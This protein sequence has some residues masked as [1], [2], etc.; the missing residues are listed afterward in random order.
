MVT[1]APW[2]ASLTDALALRAEK[3]PDRIAYIFLA[4][5]EEEQD[6][7]TYSALDT[8][9]RAIGAALGGSL[10]PGDRALLLYPPGL[11]FIAAFFGCLYAGV[12]AVPAYPPRSPRMIPRLLAMLADARPAV[13]LAPAT[14]LQRVRGWLER[15]PE[16]ALPW[17][18][19][20]ELEPARA[21]WKPAAPEGGAVAFLQYT[22]GSTSTPKGVMVT[23]GNLLHN[24]RLIQEACGHSEESVFVSWLPVYHDLGLIGQVLQ[25]VYVG[26][27][28]VLMAPVAFLQQ[29]M[30]WL[31]AVSRYRAT[32]S[33][34]PDFAY[35]LCAR[36]AGE[37]DLA[38]IDLTSWRVAFNG[39]EPVRPSTLERFAAAFAPC[40]FRA[41]AAYP[42]YGLAEATLMVSGGSPIEP[43]HVGSFRAAALERGLAEPAEPGEPGARVLAGCGRPLGDQTVLLV[44]P[45]TAEP[46][47]PGRIGEIWIAGPSVA[48]GYWERPGE[49]A[50]VFG[51]RLAGSDGRT[52]GPF[53]R[54]G[55]LGFLSGGELYV[56]G[57]IK[58]L[59]ILRGRNCYPQ[60]LELAAERSHPD[61]RPGGGAAFS[62]ESGGEEKL[63]LVHEVRRRPR[64]NAAEIAA[65]VRAALAEEH[66]VAVSEVVLIRPETLPRTSS[67]KVRRR[68]CREAYLAGE[69]SVFGRSAVDV[70]QT[71]VT[72]APVSA[73][74]DLLALPDAERRP[75]VRELLRRRVA[76]A[77]GV[78]PACVPLDETPGRLGFD[79]LG[80]AEL[81]ADIGTWLEI[82]LP[83]ADLLADLTLSEL[84][85]RI[86]SELAGSRN[87]ELPPVTSQE[88]EGPPPA[89]F[90]QERLWQLDRLEPGNPAWHLP[91]ALD[92]AGRLDPGLLER[93]L[94]ELAR[95]HDSLRMAFAEVD[96]CPVQ[97]IAAEPALELTLCNL[98]ALPGAAREAAAARLAEI[99]AWRPFDLARPPLARAALLRLGSGEHRLLL[100]VHHAV[101]DLVSLVQLT[102]ELAEIYRELSAGRPPHRPTPSIRFADFARWQRRYLRKETL[103]PHLDAW[104]RRL[105]GLSDLELPA[106]FPRRVPARPA[107][108][109]FAVPH[110]LGESLRALGRS[111]GATPFMALL[112]VFDTLLHLWTGE[113]DLVVGFPTA[114][115]PGPETEGVA[116]FFA[117]PLPLRVDLSGDPT[118]RQLLGRVRQAALDAY[119]HSVVPFAHLATVA[120]RRDRSP[121]FRTM[122]GYLDRPLREVRLPGL[123]FGPA[124]PGAV[125]TDFEMFLTF[126]RQGED[127]QAV[128]GYDGAL[129]APETLDLWVESFLGLARSCVA[130]SDRPLSRL[131]LHPGLAAR[132]QVARARRP[133]IAVAATFTAEP[134]EEPLA[135]WM[136]ELE[137]P[138][139]IRFAPFGQIFQELLDPGSLLARNA[140]GLDVLLIRFEDWQEGCGAEAAVEELVAALES[141]RGRWRVPCLV[142]LAPASPAA[143]AD[144]ERAALFRRLEERLAA[145][146]AG[147][148]GVLLA[149]PGELA[150]LYPVAAAHDPCGDEVGRIPYTP[151]M[152]AALATLIARRMARLQGPPAKVL[153]LD[154]DQTLWKGV[155]G[156]DGPL[157]I[158]VDPP[159][160]ALQELAVALHE[161]GMLL[162]LC[163]KNNEED[164][165]E[166]FA[167]RTD[168]P[169]RREHV[170]AERIN[171]RPKS[172]NLRSLA[173]EL[174]L[175][176]DS[177]VVL[178]DDPVVCAEMQAA[179][180][181]ALVLQLPEDSREIPRFLA[182]V[183]ALDAVAATTE[184]RER[185]RLYQQ[186]RQ[187]EDLRG[188]SA[189]FAD[190]LARLGL[191]V[192]FP[193]LTPE[194]LPRVAQLTQRTNQ[195]NATTLRRSEA[196][197]R[198]LCGTGGHAALLVEA[199]DRFGEYGLVGLVFWNAEGEALRVDTLL[200]SCRAMGRGVEHQMLAHL[201]SIA[202]ERG[203]RRVEVPFRPTRKNRPVLDFLTRVGEPFRQPHGEGWLFAFPAEEAA[204]LAWQ[205]ELEETAPAEN[206]QPE[207][208]ALDRPAGV[209]DGRRAAR[210]LRI[211]QELAT[212]EQVLAAMHAG[213]ELGSASAGAVAPRTPTEELLV[214]IWADLLGLERVG[215]HDDFFEL[216]GHS[217]LAA[218]VVSHLHGALGAGLPLTA[219]FE[220]PTAARLAEAVDRELRGGASEPKPPTLRRLPRDSPLPLS[221][222]QERLWFLDRLAPGCAAY[223]I[224]AG[225]RLRGRTDATALARALSAIARRHEALRTVFA[226]AGG[227]PAQVVLPPRPVPLPVI[228][229]A[230]LPDA[231]S[232]ALR[233]AAEEAARPFDLAVGP[234]LRALL[235]RIA[236]ADHLLL[237]GVHHIVADGGS[238]TVVLRELAVLLEGAPLPEP[239]VQYGDWAAWQREW[240]E[241]GALA[242]QLEAWREHLAGAPAALELPLDRPR[243]ALQSDRGAAAPVDLSDLATGLRDLAQ[244][245][246]GT[247]FIALLATFAALLQRH[248]GQDDVVVGSPVSGRGHPEVEG[249]VGLFVNTLPLRVRLGGDPSFRELLSRARESALAAFAHRDVPFEKL[250]EALVPQRDPSR[251]PLLQVMLAVQRAPAREILLPGCRAE[252]LLVHNGTSK[253]DLTLSLLE[254]CDRLAGELEWCADLFERAT[255]LRLAGH[256]R[257]L[258]AGAVA[259]PERRLSELP[260]LSG[261]EQEQLL[262][263][264]SASGPAP[265]LESAEEVLHRLFETQAART[266]GAEAL[267]A[268]ADRLTYAELDA[269]AS[270]LA[271]R[272]RGLGVGP[273]SP[274]AVLLERSADLVAA[275]LAVLKAG[276]AYVPLDPAYP[277]ERIAF[278]LEDTGARV[279]L[280]REALAAPL[281]ALPAPPPHILFLG[282][283]DFAGEGGAEPGAPVDPESLA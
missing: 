66:E 113:D 211:A 226:E 35:D 76:G 86:L 202:C 8:R 200:L 82:S 209:V 251:S 26:A 103:A 265:V 183:W 67:G 279:V 141:A 124:G 80:A 271:R 187:R 220:H 110:D 223:N 140:A 159:R 75:L 163:S 55:D 174:R 241:D 167:R 194:L 199:R 254:D 242:P 149:L 96:G 253:L 270:C 4:E 171:W 56:T 229:L 173:T 45:A 143:L 208:P 198:E 276:G 59:I 248:S 60:D 117:Y 93:A 79:S 97:V 38:G 169:L 62:V 42:C 268:G 153:V 217:L 17:L 111:E 107:R 235:L 33:G 164:V 51:A 14:S 34:G 196:E 280:T 108:R 266:P 119:A 275:L 274:V 261:P 175:G 61:L 65:A 2:I 128:L 158:E 47:P 181:E 154:C 225:L 168:M 245:E 69:L 77:L 195:F 139:R 240:L 71:P 5:G 27:S 205:P 109:T 204:A 215:I 197:V 177:F 155:C 28:C 98:S 104:R 247:P 180:P 238:M 19:T 49:T 188:A 94:G 9:A 219:L 116:G 282:L 262:V 203:L 170:A 278:A 179:C 132:A 118:F 10:A 12:I 22:S 166:V 63:V 85:E 87:R 157:G 3:T 18:A 257:E 50:E 126:F 114:G 244:R 221:F 73:W 106:D 151:E 15:T 84:A 36:R 178:D 273:E 233:L 176:L 182:H 146:L 125:A 255:A 249:V 44:D 32:T 165:A 259:D 246:G 231:E 224:H 206:P 30:R 115:R 46:L 54:T 90:E 41:T 234:L 39:A 92:L 162:A 216:G 7:L 210:A 214:G 127:L 134:L 148:S 16:A 281:V 137:V 250:V 64:A 20:D 236:P 156:E 68:A 189:S 201:G 184:D 186:E 120:R 237:A 91:V 207:T 232:A 172:E 144:P 212:P 269:Q 29:P 131:A 83:V 190:F 57:R 135:F 95:R 160:R 6:R 11:D 133:T 227:R 25:A 112:A 243:P 1:A 37:A 258:L 58:D 130:D 239:P 193:P 123:T 145:A 21:A 191:E 78:D 23:H 142:C 222:A 150:A 185:T 152:F 218:Q 147:R 230:A 89:S 48:C 228:D 53:L 70:K 72:A 277:Q 264:W 81:S 101:C 43:P 263:E 31:R 283:A 252:P 102:E 213:R 122:L 138:A 99:A 100:T 267:V 40:G 121:L 192:S 256:L 52:E 13:A 88:S 161:R 105:A 74:Q 136:R 24:Q 260:L 272:L 129:F